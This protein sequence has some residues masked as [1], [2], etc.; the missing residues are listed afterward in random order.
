MPAL[1][2]LLMLSAVL[3]AETL[4]GFQAPTPTREAGYVVEAAEEM[5]EA[6]PVTG[7]AR[8]LKVG[9]GVMPGDTVK[10]IPGKSP[11]EGAFVAI[12]LFSTGGIAKL[13]SGATVKEGAPAK[14]GI[15]VRL[16]DGI[17]RRL[18]NEALV[19]GIVRSGSLLQDSVVVGKIPLE[20]STVAPQL[21]AGPYRGRF[22]PLGPDGRPVGQWTTAEPFEVTTTGNKPS[23]VAA[24]LPPGLWQIAISHQQVPTV[25]GDAWVLITVDPAAKETFEM[26]K[27]ALADSL[28]SEGLDI[29]SA[30]FRTRRAAI[31]AL[32]DGLAAK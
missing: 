24:P 7:G 25:S 16:W 21:A 22:R 29:E 12:L 30:A 15:V 32:A 8:R 18:N 13:G 10:P 4:T 28:R 11:P 5:W 17:R 27:S 31:L 23:A 26:V 14:P 20:W 3:V 9:S 2:R 1:L 6:V 19:P